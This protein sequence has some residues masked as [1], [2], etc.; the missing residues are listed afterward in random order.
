MASK[1]LIKETILERLFIDL[2][3]GE[4]LFKYTAAR[5]NDLVGPTDVVADEQLFL[6]IRRLK[7]NRA[8]PYRD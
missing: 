2:V 5:F 6:L 1:P 8:T 3:T 7:Q 4:L